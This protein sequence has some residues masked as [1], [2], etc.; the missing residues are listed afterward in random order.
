MFYFLSINFVF[1]L[2]IIYSG[3]D[4]PGEAEHKIFD[5]FRKANVYPKFNDLTHCIYGPDAD[6]IVLSLGCHLKNMIILREKYI[7]KEVI[8]Q[9]KQQRAEKPV[10]EWVNINVLRDCFELDFEHVKEKMKNIKFDLERI[11]DDFVFICFFVGNDFLPK[12][13]GLDI[14]KG[15]LDKLIDMYKEFLQSAQD[16]IIVDDK[17]NFKTFEVFVERL[18][19]LEEEFLK[20]R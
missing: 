19:H 6:L 13:F 5:Y 7:F 18:A 8:F 12:V 10:W 2:K 15:Y 9:I 20:M 3:S 17:L 1:K 4:V 14:R 11:I 16:Y